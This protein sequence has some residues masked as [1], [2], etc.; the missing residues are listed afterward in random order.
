MDLQC[1]RS[2]GSC[3]SSD[4]NLN[5]WK[6]SMFKETVKVMRKDHAA[7]SLHRENYFAA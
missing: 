2:Y 7:T 5:N 6:T 3:Q 1:D 4:L